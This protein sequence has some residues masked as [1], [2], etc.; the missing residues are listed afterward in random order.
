MPKQPL[1]PW[2]NAL[3]VSS[4]PSKISR[5]LASQRT[6]SS[7]DLVLPSTASCIKLSW[8]LYLHTMTI[9]SQIESLTGGSPQTLSTKEKETSSTAL[10]HPRISLGCWSRQCRRD[11]RRRSEGKA[12]KLCLLSGVPTASFQHHRQRFQHHQSDQPDRHARRGKRAWKRTIKPSLDSRLLETNLGLPIHQKSETIVSTT[13][14]RPVSTTT[15]WILL[16]LIRGLVAIS[17]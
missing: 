7:S 6:L 10:Q 8:S 9:Q 11:V 16:D 1:R 13:L 3:T 15:S 5:R 17:Q 14:Q 2:R 4:S 12:L